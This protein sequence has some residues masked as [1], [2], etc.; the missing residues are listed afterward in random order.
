MPKTI[1]Q[2]KM[3]TRKMVVHTLSETKQAATAE[4]HQTRAHANCTFQR[5]MMLEV[6]LAIPSMA[7]TMATE[8]N[9]STCLLHV[10][11]I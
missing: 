10:R 5:R 11:D 3:A 9:E 4:A 7:Q 6:A 2:R 8:A 1:W